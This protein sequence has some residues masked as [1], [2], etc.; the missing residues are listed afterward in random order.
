MN[1]LFKQYR[2]FRLNKNKNFR[3]Y[4]YDE[5][6]NDYFIYNVRTKFIKRLI[7]HINSFIFFKFSKFSKFNFYRIF[8]LK[9]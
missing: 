6:D 1:K 9:K 8:Y 7:I 5:N 4:E 2:K 3:I